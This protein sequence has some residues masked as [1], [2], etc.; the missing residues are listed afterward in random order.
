[1]VRHQ[2]TPHV[3]YN[4]LG[5]YE[6]V[7]R[8]CPGDTVVTTTVDN[9]GRDASDQPVAVRPNPLTGPFYVDG[10][11]L[12]D[13]LVVHFDSV[14][15]NRCVGRSSTVV[16]Y[17][18]VDPGYVKAMPPRRRVVAEWE[19][20]LA[21]G[22]AKLV[23]PQTRLGQLVLPMKPM[24][25]CF[26]VAPANGQ[27]ISSVTSA[28]HGGNM[29]YKGFVTGVTVHLPVFA[30]GGLFF[31][32]DGHALQGAGEIVGTGVEVSFDVQF[33][34]DVLK[35]ESI[36]WP[37]AEDE[38]FIFTVGNARPLDQALQHATTE[39]LRWLQNGFGL[40]D[41]A[42]HILLG[43][44]VEYDVGNVFDP[45]YTM[46]CKLQKALIPLKS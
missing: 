21:Q 6:P 39:M 28:A 43:Q 42:A 29:D 24:V 14:W 45:A 40:D 30:P 23:A 3:Y 13:V 35:D 17:N 7:L 8:I 31:L 32:G 15:P 16:A 12:G 10:A 33:T 34:V 25:G 41:H 11:E 37:R 1:M 4:A 2:F 38:V 46:V 9:A 20:D 18:V 36:T 22:T 19:L 27:A 5:S 44:C 26:G